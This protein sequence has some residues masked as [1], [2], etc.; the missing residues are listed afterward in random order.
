MS[1]EQLVEGRLAA[2][3]AS[4]ERKAYATAIWRHAKEAK[5]ILAKLL[6]SDSKAAGEE[7]AAAAVGDEGITAAAGDE[8]ITAAAGDEEFGQYIAEALD[9]ADA[10]ERENIPNLEGNEAFLEQPVGPLAEG[11]GGGAMPDEDEAVG[12]GPAAAE[13]GAAVGEMGEGALSAEQEVLVRTAIVSAGAVLERQGWRRVFQSSGEALELLQP[14]VHLGRMMSPDLMAD[15]FPLLTE[16]LK[17]AASIDV[18]ADVVASAAA[19]PKYVDWEAEWV[20]QDIDELC[21]KLWED[22]YAVHGATSAERRQALQML[23][24]FYKWKA[25]R[26]GVKWIGKYCKTIT[27]RYV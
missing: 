16:A 15:F 12:D 26:N 5:A 9:A 3:K 21:A 25:A 19:K 24:V 4:K 11:R 22:G 10:I 7:E 1:L 27:N 13:A 17:R 14:F 6:F 23:A 18:V 8:G 2:A 20:Q